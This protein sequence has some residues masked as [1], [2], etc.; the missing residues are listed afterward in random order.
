MRLK[1]ARIATGPMSA[2]RRDIT[3]A[4]PPGSPA[5]IDLTGYLLLP[6]LINAHD[7]LE[8]NLFPRLGA[9]LYANAS[10]WAADIFHPGESP[11]KEILV[12]PKSARLAWGGLRN[13]LSGVTTVAHHNPYEAGVFDSN[14]PVRVVKNLGWAHSLEFSPNLAELYRDTSKER[15]FIVHAAEGADEGARAEIER[16]DRLGVLGPNTVLVHAL[17]LK[18][19]EI[20][21]IRERGCSIVWCP[22]S[23]LAI[24]GRTLSH[25]I[26]RSGIPIALGTDSALT[27]SGDLIDA[28]R[29]AHACGIE[30]A[31][32]YRMVTSTA[33]SILRLSDF[34]SDLIAVEDRGQTSAEALLDFH[35]R[36]VMIE[37]RIKLLAGQLRD[38][39]PLHRIDLEGR[40][41][42]FVDAD[43]H[44]L[45]EQ[46]VSA[47]GSVWTLAGKRVAA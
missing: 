27:F 31:E 8:F 39:A 9:R 25:E 26:L 2:E 12:V 42:F 47:L 18:A 13:L 28:I 3:I 7:H 37:G 5:E 15:P 19:P 6:G 14:F 30:P 29:T 1:G 22:G 46:T 44:S 41:T 40:G 4:A 36:M 17:A 43:V 45:H 20:A 24:Y 10:E 33:A 21:L 35:P 34:T 32:I 23:N 38:V 11:A 16:L